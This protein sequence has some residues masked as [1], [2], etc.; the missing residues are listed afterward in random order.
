MMATIGSLLITP[1]DYHVTD[2]KT[3]LLL[4]CHFGTLPVAWL[5]A[6]LFCREK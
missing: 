2:V 1:I 3:T 6:L 5:S 4:N